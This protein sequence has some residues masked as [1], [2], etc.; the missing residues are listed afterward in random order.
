MKIN[1]QQINSFQ[2][3]TSFPDH[4]YPIVRPNVDTLYSVGIFDLELGPFRVSF[5]S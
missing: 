5:L 3:K 2:H 1:P 4:N